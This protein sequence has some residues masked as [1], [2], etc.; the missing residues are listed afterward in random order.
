MVA[1]GGICGLT[2]A[3]SYY[4]RPRELK[5]LLVTLRM[6]ESEIAYGVNPLPEALGRVA[7]RS[8]KNVAPLLDRVAKE[9][10]AKSGDT[11]REIW[12][13]ALAAFYRNSSLLPRDLLILRSLGANLGMSDRDDQL[14]HL[15]LAKEQLEQEISLAEEEAAKN[16]KLWSYLGFLGG[17]L[18]V[19][20]LY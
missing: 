7:C 19:I 14:K 9:L 15:H 20:I 4:R 8:D 11:A 5:S 2:V 17:L 6:L 10:A 18:A 3:G 16:V 1:S 12:E 13:R